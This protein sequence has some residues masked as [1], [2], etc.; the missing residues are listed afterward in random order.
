MTKIDKSSSYHRFDDYS[1]L[2]VVRNKIVHASNSLQYI[3]SFSKFI[4]TFCKERLQTIFLCFRSFI[5]SQLVLS[6]GVCLSYRRM[7]LRINN[8]VLYVK[9]DANM[10]TLI[11]SL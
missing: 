5:G 10:F 9:L 4:L 1:S 11:A 7:Y 8:A 2:L 3:F 6:I